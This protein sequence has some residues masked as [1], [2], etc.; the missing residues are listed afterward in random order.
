[1]NEIQV[2]ILSPPPDPKKKKD[3]GVGAAARCH[4]SHGILTITYDRGFS[5]PIQFAIP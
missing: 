1:M 5:K 4:L 2:G 3:S